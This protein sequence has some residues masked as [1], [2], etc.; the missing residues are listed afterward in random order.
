MINRKIL[1]KQLKISKHRSI[2]VIFVKEKNLKILTLRAQK[3]KIKKVFWA[4]S[5]VLQRI[6]NFKKKLQLNLR[7]NLQMTQFLLIVCHLLNR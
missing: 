3:R 1:Q 4:K 7:E 5:S 2:V 6:K